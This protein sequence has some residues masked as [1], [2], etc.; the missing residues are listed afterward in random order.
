MCLRLEKERKF[1]SRL[2]LVDVHIL[3]L[4]VITVLKRNVVVGEGIVILLIFGGL[5]PEYTSG[6]MD[7][8]SVA[9]NEP[10]HEVPSDDK[11]DYHV[12]EST[13]KV[14]QK[15]ELLFN[16]VTLTLGVGDAFRYPSVA[17]SH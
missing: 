7:N 6:E 4:P 16:V 2:W 3:K 14:V 10:R 8:I 12:R 1:Y 5:L 17:K 15:D 9:R 13:V 11:E